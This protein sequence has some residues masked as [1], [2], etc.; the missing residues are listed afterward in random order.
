MPSPRSTLLIA[1]I[2]IGIILFAA[3]TFPQPAMEREIHLTILTTSNLKSRIFPPGV[4]EGIDSPGLEAIAE[5]ANR[6]RSKEEY[7]L[8]LSSGDDLIG[9][10]Y[11]LFHGEPE[12]RGMTQAGY[13]AVCPGNHEFGFGESGYARAVGYAGFP[14]VSANMIC[15]NET[16]NQTIR[17]WTIIE[18]NDL[19]IGIFGLMTPRL[20]S[21]A[22]IGPGIVVTDPLEAAEDAIKSLQEAD[23]D[24][25]ICLSH[26]GEAEDTRL[27]ENVA[28]LHVIIGGHDHIVLQKEVPNPDN[29]IIPIVQ[30]GQYGDNLGILRLTLRDREMITWSFEVLKPD[31]K[32]ASVSA[33]LAPFI[34]SYKNE[35]KKPI[36]EITYPLDTRKLIVRGGEAT[37]GDLITDAWRDWFPEADIAFINGGSIRGDRIFPAGPVSWGMMQEILPFGSELVLVHMTE[38]EIQETLEI[39]AS[40]L[41]VPGDES[42]AGERP[43]TGGF[44]QVS[45]IRFT[46]DTEGEP[47]CG[48]YDGKNLTEIMTPGG[49]VSGI[50]VLGTFGWDELKQGQNYTVVVNSWLASGGDGH[51]ALAEAAG[52]KFAGT[53]VR[54]IDPVI[55]AIKRQSMENADWS[56]RIHIL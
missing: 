1:A 38:K 48:T 56:K 37:V 41:R 21:I 46:I 42:F 20:S 44:L 50:E 26:M 34:T 24:V 5:T 45:G 23:V 52:P 28:G 35:M 15:S 19:R 55:V 14:I 3:L 17:P 25:I 53:T 4:E 51:Y 11:S 9:A 39:S 47:F 10:I 7:S 6:I 33:I 30:A 18:Q 27:A 12:Y 31:G 40:A 54:D 8:L 32:D 2:I 13:D 29:R 22:P 16:L 43:P 49:R 36:G